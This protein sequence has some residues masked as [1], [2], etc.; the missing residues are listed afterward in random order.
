MICRAIKKDKN[1]FSEWLFG[2]SFADY[3]SK[4]N[5]IAQDIY[6]ALYEFKFD[7]FFALENGI[8]W[9]TRLGMKEQKEKL[10]ED[11]I[12]V[13]QNR[14]GVLSAYDFESNVIGRQYTCTCKVFTEYSDKDINIEFTI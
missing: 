5:Q 13:I 11:V 7:C 8:D 2:H 1:N 14:Q 9:N 12:K 10:D 6:T 3:R 4:Q